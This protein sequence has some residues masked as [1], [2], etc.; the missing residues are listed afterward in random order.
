MIIVIIIT[1]IKLIQHQCVKK[2]YRGA[3]KIQTAGR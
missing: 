2:D 3:G 1:I